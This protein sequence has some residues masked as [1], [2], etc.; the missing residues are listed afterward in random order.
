MATLLLLGSAIAFAPRE[1]LLSA[2]ASGEVL[3]SLAAPAAPLAPLA[4]LRVACAVPVHALD[5]LPLVEKCRLGGATA[6]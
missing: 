4:T 5:V 3:W 2:A 6:R 1:T